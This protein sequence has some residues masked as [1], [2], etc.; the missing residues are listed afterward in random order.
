MLSQD[1]SHVG[2]C[3][4]INHPAKP[5]EQQFIEQ[6]GCKDLQELIIVPSS[7]KLISFWNSEIISG[8]SLLI[9][10]VVSCVSI[11]ALLIANTHCGISIWDL[12]LLCKIALVQPQEI[13]TTAAIGSVK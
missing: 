12:L 11:E 9:T 8:I 7:N 6:A 2:S 1:G 4:A 10:V 3:S 13:K 5:H